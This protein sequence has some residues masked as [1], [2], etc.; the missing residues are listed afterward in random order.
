MNKTAIIIAVVVIIT[1]ALFLLPGRAKGEIFPVAESLPPQPQP[2]QIPDINGSSVLTDIVRGAGVVSAVAP[3]I[4]PAIGA[5]GTALGISTPAAAAAVS[6][7]AAAIPTAAVPGVVAESVL[8]AGGTTAQATTAA[9]AASS[10]IAAGG[11]STSAVAAGAGAVPIIAGAIMVGAFVIF[12]V[13]ILSDI[14][15]DEKGPGWVE[16]FGRYQWELTPEELEVI[17]QDEEMAKY[18]A[19][20]LG[21]NELNQTVVE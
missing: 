21:F 6:A 3:L 17:R 4:G 5:V 10:N 16:K 12:A 7:G 11:S 2:N 15:Y 1:I 13:D 18:T 9:A 20:I 14:G 19:E 8:A